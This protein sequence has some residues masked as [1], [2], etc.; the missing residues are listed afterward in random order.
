MKSPTRR[1][2]LLVW[3]HSEGFQLFL[4]LIASVVRPIRWTAKPPVHTKPTALRQRT[5][6]EPRQSSL[7]HRNG[8]GA[9]S[10]IVS[11]AMSI[12]TTIPC[13]LYFAALFL[14]VATLWIL[15]YPNEGSS[16]QDFFV[17]IVVVMPFVMLVY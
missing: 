10:I 6:H 14:T 9:R 2:R 7:R 17:F 16:P 12:P 11:R 15:L 5:A 13:L 4:I 3:S 1:W 8:V